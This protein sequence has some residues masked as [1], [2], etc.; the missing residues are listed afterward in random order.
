MIQTT[1]LNG[2]SIFINP[3]LIETVE[4]TPDTIIT[5]TSGKKYVIKESIEELVKK[6]IMYQQFVRRPLN[7][8]AKSA[9][10]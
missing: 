10:E 2:M 8:K 1:R 3:E 5:L 9:E 7:E 4:K 6:F